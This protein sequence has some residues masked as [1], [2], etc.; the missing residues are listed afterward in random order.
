MLRAGYNILDEETYTG[1][2]MRINQAR[3]LAYF[4]LLSGIFNCCLGQASFRATAQLGDG[5]DVDLRES[6]EPDWDA[7]DD[8]SPRLVIGAEHMHEASDGL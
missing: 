1:S 4:Y 8:T 7:S 2:Q 5:G 6:P 3:W